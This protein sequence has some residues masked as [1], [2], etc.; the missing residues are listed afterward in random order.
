VTTAIRARRAASPTRDL[1]RREREI[2]EI[3]YRLGRA[4]VSDVRARIDDAVSYSA[5]RTML[6]YLE[7]KGHLRHERDGKRYVYLPTAPKQKVGMSAL[8]HVVDTFFDGSVD[9][10]VLALVS[11]RRGGAAAAELDRLRRLIDAE[12][13]DGKRP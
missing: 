10:V 12:S 13:A 6:T 4:T 9:A 5:V 7:T 2:L 11:T 3:V 8:R 1:G